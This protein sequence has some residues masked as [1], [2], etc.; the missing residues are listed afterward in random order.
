[1]RQLIVVIAAAVMAAVAPARAW[2]EAS[3]LSPSAGT[4]AHCLS[5]EPADA[6]ARLSGSTIDDCPALESARP[7]TAARLDA[8][9]V[10]VVTP[11]PDL[12]A[13]ARLVLT[14]ERPRNA[15]TV[16]ERSTPLRI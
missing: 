4:Q 8:K 2:C 6:A 11:A 14:P 7:T 1:V 16:F 9:A 5:H 15:S 3:C 12:K 13:R 10:A